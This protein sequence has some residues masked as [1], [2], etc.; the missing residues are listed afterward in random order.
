MEICL[1]DTL[2]TK[3]LYHIIIV[4]ELGVKNLKLI[5]FSQCFLYSP[6]YNIIIIILEIQ[7]YKVLKQKKKKKKKKMKNR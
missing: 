7:M 5:L 2:K 1:E 6:Y 3:V 4:S